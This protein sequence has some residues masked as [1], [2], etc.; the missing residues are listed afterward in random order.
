MEN[1]SLQLQLILEVVFNII[2]YIVNLLFSLIMIF[3]LRFQLDYEETYSF[4]AFGSGGA[5]A[6]WLVAAVVSAIDSIPVVSTHSP[7]IFAFSRH[8]FT[9]PNIVTATKSLGT[10]RPWLHSLVHLPISSFKGMQ[11]RYP[12]LNHFLLHV[13]AA[14]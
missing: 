10:C 13:T 7:S 11:L 9:E 4:L 5:V 12:L 1:K 3:A 8:A 6:L 2:S 14:S